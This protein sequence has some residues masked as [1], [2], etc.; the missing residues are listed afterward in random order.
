MP[1]EIILKLAA[2]KEMKIMFKAESYWDGVP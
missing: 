1:L 2:Q